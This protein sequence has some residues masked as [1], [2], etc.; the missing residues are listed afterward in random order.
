MMRTPWIM[1]HV[2]S[3]D[4]AE[5]LEHDKA[6]TLF[7]VRWKS[8]IE[9]WRSYYD[10]K[11]TCPNKEP[12]QATK[13]A[14]KELEEGSGTIYSSVDV[15]LEEDKK[16]VDIINE[17]PHYKSEAGIETLDVIEA[18]SLDFK[19]GNVVKYVLRHDRKGNPLA[20]LKKA[21]FYLDRKIK[22]LENSK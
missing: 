2:T 9:E 4:Q 19:L 15:L 6:L 11:E 16:P 12:N 17:P 20:D 7:K 18:F 1:H 3:G 21:R 22:Q 13:D 14:L 8:G 5:V 10:F